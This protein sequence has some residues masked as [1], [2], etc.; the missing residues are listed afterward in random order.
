MR[1]SRWSHTYFKMHFEIGVGIFY[2][3]LLLLLLTEK[4]DSFCILSP[5]NH[6]ILADKW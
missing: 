5:K 3:L 2:F 1:W 6:V 4:S